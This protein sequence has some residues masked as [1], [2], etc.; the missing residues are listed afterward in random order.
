[1]GQRLRMVHEAM[2]PKKTRPNEK[3]RN[4][5]N[6]FA[7]NTPVY[8]RD[9]RLG[10]QWTAAIIKKRHGSMIYDVELEQDGNLLVSR[11]IRR[12]RPTGDLPKK[13]D[14][15]RSDDYFPQLPIFLL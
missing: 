12:R 7:A 2:L 8:A 6:G 10:R 14:V 13:G 5:K 1:M 15:R 9:Y 11:S 4:K 3:R